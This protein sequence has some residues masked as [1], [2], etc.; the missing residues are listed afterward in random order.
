MDHSEALNSKTAERY[1]LGELTASQ[2]DAFEEHFF[3][4]TECAADVKIA[5]IFAAN[6]HE[7]M[8]TA[9]TPEI[10]A[11]PRPSPAKGWFGWLRPG[12]AMGLVALLV[13]TLGYQNLVTIPRMNRKVAV[14]S[15]QA[16][17]TF[18]LATSGTRGANDT[19]EI[20]VRRSAPFGIYVDIPNSDKFASYSCEVR[21][22][23][24]S[25]KLNIN[26]SA[27]QAKDAVQL[28][29]PGG[30]LD[31]GQYDVVVLG[32]RSANGTP[33]SEEVV[34]HGFTVKDLP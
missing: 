21:T 26:V 30:T 9:P 31:A 18:S 7:A 20:A 5:A 17:P 22:R 34:R 25:R 12:Y 28:F 24:G 3:G 6:A 29:I 14:N 13:A 15:P 33:G 16:L 8:G 32:Y 2:R 23:A 11:A 27:A 10:V 19:T 1:L 4:C